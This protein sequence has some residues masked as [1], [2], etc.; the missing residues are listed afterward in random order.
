MG[1]ASSSAAPGSSFLLLLAT[2]GAPAG[3]TTIRVPA[4]VCADSVLHVPNRYS[5]P[6]R[7]PD[8][9]R[10]L[11]AL[12]CVY[13]P[14]PH[15]GPQKRHEGC[16]FDGQARVFGEDPISAP[17][18]SSTGLASRRHSATNAP[19][20]LKTAQKHH[21]SW[22]AA[23]PQRRYG[24]QRCLAFLTVGWHAERGAAR[25]NVEP[26][27]AGDGSGA[28]SCRASNTL[29]L[30]WVGGST[31]CCAGEQCQPRVCALGCAAEPGGPGDHPTTADD[32]CASQLSRLQMRVVEL[33]S[34]L[35]SAA[36]L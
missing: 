2:D 32:A 17:S 14:T 20:N 30:C 31:A 10:L 4:A 22:W 33:E 3:R 7:P 11:S 27:G 29:Q 8:Q 18:I 19:E 28:V 34:Q 16:K 24:L 36:I 21:A 26:G 12:L 9:A 5:R 35:R 25:V 23:V 13:G 15:T 6:A 1:G